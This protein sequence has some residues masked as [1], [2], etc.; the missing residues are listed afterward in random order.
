[1]LADLVA[2]AVIAFYAV[3]GFRRG[4]AASLLGFWASPPP[5]W[6]PGCSGTGRGGG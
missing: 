3:R 2:L 6:R 5:W 1:M 4:L